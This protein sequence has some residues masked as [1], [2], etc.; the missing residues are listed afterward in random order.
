MP[1][2]IDGYNLLNAAGIVGQGRGP[3]TLE[4]ARLALLNFLAESVEPDELPLTTVVFDA[5]DAPPGL[6]RVVGYRG[7]TVRFASRWPDADS[8]IE[9]LIRRDASPRRLLVV[10][11]DHRLHRAA[12]RRRARAID[13]DVW[14]AQVVADRRRRAEQAQTQPARP[15]VPLLAEDVEYWFDRFG[16]EAAFDKVLE[17]EKAREKRP[18]PE[19]SPAEKA[20]DDAYNPFPPGYAEDVE[21]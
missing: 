12:R 3:A 4:R 1:L 8:L 17:E 15:P 20:P 19:P 11:S 21:E 2:L 14:Y 18:T 16:G 7:L 13:A 10:S 5:K 6:P 9:E